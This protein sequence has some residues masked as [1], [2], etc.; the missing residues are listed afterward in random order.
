MKDM[1][2]Q[3]ISFHF[4]ISKDFILN[5]ENKIVDAE[6]KEDVE[7]AIKAIFDVNGLKNTLH[8]ELRKYEKQKKKK[9]DDRF[10]K[11]D[12]EK[13]QSFFGDLEVMIHELAEI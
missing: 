13:V 8:N 6:G 1:Q 12:Y 9:G 10:F 11:Y 4:D 2:F 7:A 3:I 5:T